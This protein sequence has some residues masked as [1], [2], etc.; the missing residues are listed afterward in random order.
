MEE[1]ETAGINNADWNATPPSIQ[2]IVISTIEELTKVT[3]ECSIY[4]NKETNPLNKLKDENAALKEQLANLVPN[5][6]TGQADILL[7]QLATFAKAKPRTEKQVV[8]ICE[9]ACSRQ[10]K[11]AHGLKE[12]GWDVI[13][14]HK[15]PPSFDPSKYFS[16]SYQFT[17]HF[18]LIAMACNFTPVA[19]HCFST[20]NFVTTQE[21]LKY[22][23]GKII[24]DDYD[25][26]AGSLVTELEVVH[27]DALQG[28]RICIE[29]ADGMVHRALNGQYS[30][31]NLGY[32]YPKKQIFYPEYC[33]DK[34]EN[35]RKPFPK[36][37]TDAIHVTYVGTVPDPDRFFLEPGPSATICDKHL[38]RQFTDRGVHYHL[39]PFHGGM[40]KEKRLEAWRH[41][42]AEAAENKLFHIHEHVDSDDLPE[43]LAPYHFG[44]C[45]IS[46]EIC[47]NGQDRY[48]KLR[49]FQ[50][51]TCNKAF[52]YID[53]NI[54]HVSY[55][56]DFLERLIGK[57]GP[58][59]I[60]SREKS[61][62]ILSQF[63]PTQF[64]AQFKDKLEVAR[65]RLSV[66]RHAPRL[67]K[68]YNWVGKD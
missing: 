60:A 24:F 37:L 31:K 53:A 52:D 44:L 67:A 47:K 41:M 63:D 15:Y 39:F 40:S 22:S 11:I 48:Y 23:P 2:A 17:G 28:E 18:D 43:A 6:S 33:W 56:W 21:V 42:Y 26:F 27:K 1:S 61:A 9:F 66:W 16:F 29:Q 13:L 49:N 20:G 68:F 50:N 25:L 45:S 14:L 32:K 8:F 10:V 5:F 36:K 34:T 57:D 51:G 12:S 58:L 54:V 65:R 7:R 55:G 64:E 62:E 38:I 30:K 59:V 35:Y 19:Y 3:D 4:R 46:E